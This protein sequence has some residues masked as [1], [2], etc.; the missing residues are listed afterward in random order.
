MIKPTVQVSIALLF[1]RSKV[2]VGW[3]EAKQH[4]GNKHEF[5]GGKVESGESPEQAC[6]REIFEEVG[7]EVK[8]W[9]VFDVIRHEYDDIH[10][11]LHLFH[12]FVEEQQLEV[13]RQPWAWYERDQLAE[14]NFP[15]ANASIIQRLNWHRYIKISDAI[16]KINQL[17]LEQL[18]YF[19]TETLTD[20][21]I[22]RMEQLNDQQLNQLMINVQ[23]WQYLTPNLKNKIK[24][25][26]Y[27]QSQL[28]Q[29]DVESKPVGIRI[30]AACHDK[31]SL[32]HAS[33]MGVDAVFL[34]P[35]HS[36]TTHPD[37]TALGW[38]RFEEWSHLVDMPIFA[39]GGIAPQDL[40]LAQSHG[41]YGVAGI[42]NF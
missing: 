12:A 26:H 9:Y 11:H 20:E 3:R 22:A 19:R 30:I 31:T 16:E 33:N 38:K 23:Q 1:H 14:L 21:L 39:L 13:I 18:F 27:K 7:I 6:R 10:V 5:P 34:S 41:A 42:R 28:M 17:K 24:T 36:T 32:L 35:I 8:K 2:L 29:L 40:A 25:V 37:A 4:Q 15:Q